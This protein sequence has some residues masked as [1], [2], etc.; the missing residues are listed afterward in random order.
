MTFHGNIHILELIEGAKKAKGLTVI[1]DVFRAFSVES[2]LAAMGAESIRPAGSIEEAKQLALS[3][4]GCITIGERLGRQ[5]PGFDFGNSPSQIR[6]SK[7]RIPGKTII[8]TTSA[9]T[10]GIVNATGADEIILGSLTM[11]KAIS[12]YILA[13]NPREVSLV[14]MGD[15][16]TRPNEEDELCARYIRSL[17]LG[18]A[19]DIKTAIDHLKTH[20]GKK[21]FDPALQDVYPEP[22]YAMCVNYDA[23]D[24]VLKAESD[25]AGYLVKIL[26]APFEG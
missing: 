5:L 7:D 14:C 23:F 24:F 3:Y 11:A 25:E 21:F 9:G 16:G 2:Y 22:D 4:P 13:R 15:N 6:D 26:H 12:Q 1:I 18:E 10:Q 17:L 19:F 8:H 20:G